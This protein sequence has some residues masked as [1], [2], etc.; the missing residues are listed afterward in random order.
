MHRTIIIIFLYKFIYHIP[1]DKVIIIHGYLS[2]CDA[3]I[4]TGSVFDVSK[5]SF[6]KR[7][8]VYFYRSPALI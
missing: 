5:S 3:C 6:A 8:S 1:V 4:M 2:C 7:I